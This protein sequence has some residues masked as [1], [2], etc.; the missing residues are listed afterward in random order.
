MI[1]TDIVRYLCTLLDT[2]SI[3]GV[4]SLQSEFLEVC[5]APT[6][7]M[8]EESLKEFETKLYQIIS[9]N[10][11]HDNYDYACVIY[12]TV[13]N[14]MLD[15]Y[16]DPIYDL[17]CKLDECYPIWHALR[18][19]KHELSHKLDELKPYITPRNKNISK[20]VLDAYLFASIVFKDH[21]ECTDYTNRRSE[22]CARVVEVR[23]HIQRLTTLLRTTPAPVYSH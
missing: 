2:I 4:S 12:I 6:A 13:R 8:L 18:I 11:I 9:E 16:P 22:G 14:R 3:P 23:R 5:R 15:I 19:E 10:K 20:E 1:R 7:M 17:P 21:S